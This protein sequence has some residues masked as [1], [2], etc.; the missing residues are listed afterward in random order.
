[1]NIYALGDLHFSFENK[2]S[3]LGKG[4]KQHKPMDC[5]GEKWQNHF[6]KIYRNWNKNIGEQDYILIPGDISW[7]MD[8]QD[9]AADL[10]FL[11]LLKGKKIILKGNHDYWW[12]SINR[13]REA[14]PDNCF[15]LQNDSL[16]IN[17]IAVAGTRGWQVPG[18]DNFSEHDQKIF[19]RE[20]NRLQL[21]LDSINKKC[22]K[23]IV[24]FHYMPVNPS[25]EKNSLIEVLLKREVDLCIYGHLHGQQAHELALQGSK[26]GIDFKLVSA[27]YL[28]FTP[29]LLMENK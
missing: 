22:R 9:A 18:T 19:D 4:N 1:M 28:D 3:D 24:M 5:F 23:K 12:N 29:R 8:L 27:D 15:A 13:V 26:W 7:A 2:V 25:F 10:H 16:L 21:S 20:V 17:N 11:Q 14:L 6:M